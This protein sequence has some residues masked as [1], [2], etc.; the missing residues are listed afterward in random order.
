MIADL[1]CRFCVFVC[2][3][4]LPCALV[5]WLPLH[6]SLLFCV[7]ESLRF[8][9]RQ[10]RTRQRQWWR[11]EHGI[12]EGYEQAKSRHARKQQVRR[13]HYYFFVLQQW[14]RLCIGFR[15]RQWCRL[16]HEFERRL[17]VFVVR[18]QRI[19][20]CT[21]FVVQLVLLNLCLLF[22]VLWQVG[23]LCVAGC[24][25]TFVVGTGFVVLIKLSQQ[26]WW[27]TR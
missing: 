10:C 8:F 17:H 16:L 7:A 21:V 25:G 26:Q 2:A 23:R 27:R 3:L 13:R 20:I 14:Q 15:C 4:R 24:I 19:Y 5:R 18:Q 9:G 11:D 12:A 22:V 1:F 6:R